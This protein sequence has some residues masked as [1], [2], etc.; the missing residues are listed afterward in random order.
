MKHPTLVQLVTQFEDHA[1]VETPL[2]VHLVERQKKG[3]NF[4][5]IME[6]E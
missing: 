5:L 4:T 1:T 2:N 3:S 6:N